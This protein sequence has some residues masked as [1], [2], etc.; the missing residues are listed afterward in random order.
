MKCILI[1]FANNF[2]HSTYAAQSDC[3]NSIRYGNEFECDMREWA[4]EWRERING[5]VA[6]VHSRMKG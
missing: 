3:I 6:E 5:Q 1:Y 4:D 2:R